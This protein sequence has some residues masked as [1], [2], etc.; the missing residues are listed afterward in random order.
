MKNFAL[1]PFVVICALL[2]AGASVRAQTTPQRAATPARMLALPGRSLSPT[3]TTLRPFTV[4]NL[5]QT[6][7][8]A[9]RPKAR[10]FNLDTAV[11]RIL[12]DVKLIGIVGEFE[13]AV[14]NA[15]K[16]E[17]TVYPLL[18]HVLDGQVRTEMDI[19]AASAAVMSTGPFTAIRSVG[20][21]RVI[22][23]TQ[24][25]SN[26][27]VSSQVFPEAKCY[28]TRELPAE[29]LLMLIRIEK[30]SLGQ[31][32]LG[33]IPCEK[34]LV[35]LVYPTGDKREGRAWSAAGVLRQVQFDVGD[36]RLTVRVQ[37]SQGLADLQAQDIA[38]QKLALFELP[39]G[40]DKC[41]DL[42]YVVTRFHARQQRGQ[43]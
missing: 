31:E 42:E 4:T 10:D 1:Q 37:D 38:E 7:P 30:R 32:I 18:V 41:P 3:A 5:S 43:R 17:V 34:S 2:L 19:T 12:A 33:G 28:I 26:L 29:D 35:T 9:L 14:T 23:L 25:Q 24:V 20:L 11:A 13:L 21:T 40:Y 15:G 36:S 8:A 6:L 39:K 22:N 16:T 27:R